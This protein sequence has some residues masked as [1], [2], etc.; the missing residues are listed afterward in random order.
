MKH[1]TKKIVIIKQRMQFHSWDKKAKSWSRQIPDFP[2]ATQVLN[3][4]ALYHNPCL[5]TRVHLRQL[6]LNP[7][8]VCQHLLEGNR[9]FNISE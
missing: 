7:R 1:T 3:Q 9:M 2:T 4:A 8:D 6:L 5:W